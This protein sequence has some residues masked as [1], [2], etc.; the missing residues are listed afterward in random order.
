MSIQLRQISFR[1]QS[2]EGSELG[3]YYPSLDFLGLKFLLRL[4]QDKKKYIYIKPGIISNQ[5]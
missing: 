2:R 4:N 5:F 1:T 3:D